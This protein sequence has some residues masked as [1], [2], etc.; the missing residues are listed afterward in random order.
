MDSTALETLLIGDT[1]KI[2]ATITE[3]YI[4]RI[5]RRLPMLGFTRVYKL[6]DAVPRLPSW[7]YATVQRS[8]H[9]TDVELDDNPIGNEGVSLLARALGKLPPRGVWPHALARVATLTNVIFEV[10]CSKPSLVPSAET[11]GKEVAECTGVPKKRK[12]VDE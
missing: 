1:S 10:L 3:L 2:T 8:H 4:D 5:Y 7:D 6:W 9:I 12:R 11:E